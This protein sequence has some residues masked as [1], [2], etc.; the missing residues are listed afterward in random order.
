MA[1]RATLSLTDFGTHGFVAYSVLPT[2]LT[3]R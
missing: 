1:M 2:V 3:G